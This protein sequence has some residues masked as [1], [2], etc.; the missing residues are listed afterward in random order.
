MLGERCRCRRG[1]G[2]VVFLV[3]IMAYAVSAFAGE[4]YDFTR[5]PVHL[6]YADWQE[7]VK[8]EGGATKIRANGRGGVLAATSLDLSAEHSAVLALTLKIAETNR[9]SSLQV[10]LLD[11]AGGQGAGNFRS[12]VCPRASWSP[13]RPRGM[14]RWRSPRTARA[15]SI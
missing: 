8:Q 4:V 10:R 13:C 14:P 9:A 3:G 2:L 7:S 15:S 5:Q 11:I 12:P 1:T 6:A